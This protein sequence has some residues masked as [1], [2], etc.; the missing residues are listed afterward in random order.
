MGFFIFE[1]LQNAL[2]SDALPT[3]RPMTHDAE[4]PVSIMKLFDDIAYDKCK[5]NFLL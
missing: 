4:D 2:E 1:N 5:Y 3:T